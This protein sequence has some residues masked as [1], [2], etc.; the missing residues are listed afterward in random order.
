MVSLPGL[1]ATLSMAFDQPDH[2]LRSLL[3]DATLAAWT[4]ETC[5]SDHP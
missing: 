3:H 4:I 5:T 1:L 2:I